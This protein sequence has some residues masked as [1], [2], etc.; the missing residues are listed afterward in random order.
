M[1]VTSNIEIN[2]YFIYGIDQVK[3]GITKRIRVDLIGNFKLADVEELKEYKYEIVDGHS[4]QICA[5]N[6][7]TK[8][9]QAL[10]R[11][12]VYIDIISKKKLINAKLDFATEF[13]G[14]ENDLDGIKRYQSI[15]IELNSKVYTGD[16]LGDMVDKIEDIFKE[17][18]EEYNIQASRCPEVDD[19]FYGDTFTYEASYG[20]I[21]PAKKDIKAVWKTIKQ[22]LNLK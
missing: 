19:N 17:E 20:D 5:F 16:E 12:V 4:D 10:K 13:F 21:T 2:K 3:E 22:Q 7:L 14:E 1:V 6:R 9:K 8:E 11:K 15:S 18:L